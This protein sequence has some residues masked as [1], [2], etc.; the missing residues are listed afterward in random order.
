MSHEI[1]F[2]STIDIFSIF[3]KNN[4]LVCFQLVSNTNLIAH[5]TQ[6]F[7]VFYKWMSVIGSRVAGQVK[8]REIQNITDLSTHHRNNIHEKSIL[9]NDGLIFVS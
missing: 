5:L 1:Y 7:I 2:I 9:I 8:R 6:N 3:V 4:F